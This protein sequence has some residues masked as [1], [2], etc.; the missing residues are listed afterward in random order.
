MKGTLEF[1]PIRHL[2]QENLSPLF[3][4]EHI[5][6]LFF[7]KDATAIGIV[8][9]E[10]LYWLKLKQKQLPIGD[11]NSHHNNYD[12]LFNYRSYII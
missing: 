2:N 9:E 1:V 5:N 3:N 4:Q 11:F 6:A 8:I 12:L 7:N 10:K